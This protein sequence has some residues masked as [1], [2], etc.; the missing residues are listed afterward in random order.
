MLPE[1][2]I[3]SLSSRDQSVESIRII[4]YIILPPF[5]PPFVR[6]LCF[7]HFDLSY[8]RVLYFVYAV[9]S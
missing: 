9:M 2:S 8:I 1:L 5:L 6:I 4:I 3:K 7:Q